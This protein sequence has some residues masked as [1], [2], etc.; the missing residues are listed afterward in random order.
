MPV[1]VAERHE[2]DSRM[3]GSRNRQLPTWV[4]AVAVTGLLLATRPADGAGQGVACD[5]DLLGAL[6]LPVIRTS[7]AKAPLRVAP[8]SDARVVITLPP[9]IKVALLD[10]SDGWF[11]VSYRDRDRNRRLYVSE[12]DAEGPSQASL[13]PR[14]IQVLEWANEHARACDRVA[15]ARFAVKSLAAAAV[16]AGLTSIIWHVY[17]EDDDHYGTGFAVWSSVSVASLVG[18]AYKAIG[19]SHAKK[20]VAELGGPSFA[21]ASAPYGR[22]GV[23]ADL[24]FDAATRRLAVVATWRP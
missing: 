14:Q 11:A 20:D 10:R 12:Q 1:T 13:S 3:A 18:V 17:I 6:Q 16:I 19:L 7:A 5:V 21:G 4:A 15:G 24:R 2:G 23:G 8:E 9:D 22:G